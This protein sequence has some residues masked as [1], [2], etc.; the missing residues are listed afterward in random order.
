MVGSTKILLCYLEL[1][2]HRC[3][4]QGSEQRTVWFARLEVH[5]TVLN[6]DNDIIGKLAVKWHKLLICLIGTIATLGLIDK[7][8]P[9]HN[10]M[11]RLE[12]ASQ[13]IGTISMCASEVLRTRLSFGV[14]LHEKSTE[15]WNQLVYLIHFILPPSDNIRIEWI[16][17]L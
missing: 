6:L 15:I 17:C 8:A 14:R 13:H 3:F 4:L 5:R 11:M 1:H 16:S 12:Y 10:T 7:G 9:H 2:H